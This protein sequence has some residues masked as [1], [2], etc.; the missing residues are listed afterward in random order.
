MG[1][2]YHH[3]LATQITFSKKAQNMDMYM[4]NYN[5]FKKT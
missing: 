5:I 3:V 1:F 4:K 2:A